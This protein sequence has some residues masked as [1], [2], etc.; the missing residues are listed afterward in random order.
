V[1]QRLQAE[2]VGGDVVEF[3]P[4]MDSSGMTAIVA[5]KLVKEIAARISE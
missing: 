5:A 3:N 4:Q 2:I 1:I